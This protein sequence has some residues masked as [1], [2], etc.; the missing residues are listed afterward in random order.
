M[1]KIETIINTMLEIT[2][3]KTHYRTEDGSVHAVDGVSFS[4]DENETLGLVGESGSGKTTIARS[5]NRT[6]PDNAEIISGSVVYN[7]NDLTKLSKKQ[8]RKVQWNDIALISQS[9]MNAF[10]PVYT[11]GEQIVEVIQAHRPTVSKA[12]A[13]ERVN[14]LFEFVNLDR[15]RIR[16]YPHQFSGGMRQR[17]AI[18]LALALDPPL[19]LADEP[20]TAL[21]VI[22][23]NQILTEI[24]SLQAEIDSSMIMIT[25]DIS[26]VSETCDRIAIV[27]GGRIVECADTESILTDPRH[28]YTM[29]LRNAFPT[30]EKGDQDLISIPGS[31]PD[32]TN[33]EP[34]CRFADRCPFAEERCYDETPERQEVEPGHFVECHRADEYKKLQR[35]ARK[36]ETWT[37]SSSSVEE[38]KNE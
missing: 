16:D 9:A 35:E 3:L 6:L 5:I 4:L 30:I 1:T 36:K 13:W 28:P 15:N 25:H 26:V 31:P 20:T 11:V 23:Q 21:D 27:Y 12:E 24:K 10:D 17:A 19:L 38:A 33:P 37:D 18:A 32:L 2:N 22:V 7:G 34:G 14:D 8:L 29:G